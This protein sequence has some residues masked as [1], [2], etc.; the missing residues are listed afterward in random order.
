M[1][2]RDYSRGLKRFLEFHALEPKHFGPLP[3]FRMP[4]SIQRV[5][6]ARWIAYRSTKWE[7]KP[8]DYIHDHEGKVHTHRPDTNEGREVAIPQWLQRTETLVRLGACLGFAYVADGEEVEAKVQRPLPFL[9]CTPCG[10]ALL[11][12]VGGSLQALIWGG[13]L[14]VTE[15]GIV[16]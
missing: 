5:G 4:K 14:D 10:H 9:Y 11:I 13:G 16:G 2:P 3:G 15:R 6:E 7:G 8:H 12:L 1:A